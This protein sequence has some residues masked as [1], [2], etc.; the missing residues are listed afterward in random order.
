[1][2]K[3][4]ICLLQRGSTVFNN[5]LITYCLHQ[6]RKYPSL[7]LQLEYSPVKVFSRN[8]EKQNNSRHI[9]GEKTNLCY[10]DIGNIYI[11]FNN[12]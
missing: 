7:D 9:R 2:K 8:A 1:M 6:R 4:N 12:A 11:F 5:N 10:I 3:E